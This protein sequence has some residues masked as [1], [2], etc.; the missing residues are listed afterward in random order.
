MKNQ[1]AIMIVVGIVCIS[2]SG[3]HSCQTIRSAQTD[4]PSDTIQPMAEEDTAE[5]DTGWERIHGVMTCVAESGCE[6]AGLH[7]PSWYVLG[8]E[9]KPPK[10]LD[11]YIL[12]FDGY[13]CN[14]ESCAC[15]ESAVRK[16]AYCNDEQFASGDSIN[17]VWNS[18]FFSEN[19]GH[20]LCGKGGVCAEGRCLCDGK[21][22]GPA[23]KNE[24]ECLEQR[25]KS[26]KKTWLCSN[27][28][29]CTCGDVICP[30]GATCHNGRCLCGTTDVT[31]TTPQQ[32]ADNS[33]LWCVDDKLTCTQEDGCSCGGEVCPQGAICH[34]GRCL[35]GTMD[36][37]PTTPQQRA[38]NPTLWCFNDKLIC[39]QEDGCSCGGEF[40]PKGTI[41][42][43][44]QCLCGKL[45]ISA[46]GPDVPSDLS[47]YTC[48]NDALLICESESCQCGDQIIE[49]E[50][51]EDCE[52]VV[53]YCVNG[54]ILEFHYDLESDYELNEKT[55]ISGAIRLEI[56]HFASC[57]DDFSVEKKDIC[58]DPNGCMT[59]DGHHMPFLYFLEYCHE[60]G[61]NEPL[62][63]NPKPIPGDGYDCDIDGLWICNDSTCEC[64]ENTCPEGSQCDNGKCS[65]YG[66]PIMAGYDCEEYEDG[67]QRCQQDSCKCGAETIKRDERCYKNMPVCSKQILTGCMCKGDLLK[68]RLLP[69]PDG[70]TCGKQGDFVCQQED[71][72]ICGNTK[73]SKNEKCQEGQCSVPSWMCDGTPDNLSDAVNHPTCI[74]NM[75]CI[76]YVD[77]AEFCM[78]PDGQSTIYRYRDKNGERKQTCPAQDYISTY[79]PYKDRIKYSG[80]GYWLNNNAY[81]PTCG[82]DFVPEHLDSYVCSIHDFEDC[83]CNHSSCTQ[84]PD[85]D[86]WLCID[87][88]GCKCGSLSC[89]VGSYCNK[90]NGNF[91]CGYQNPVFEKIC[92]TKSDQ[93]VCHSFSADLTPEEISRGGLLPAANRIPYHYGPAGWICPDDAGCACGNAICPK[94]HY[95]LGAGQCSLNTGTIPNIT[96][97]SWILGEVDTY[98]YYR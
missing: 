24:Y 7:Y 70:Y 68:G 3:C 32:R 9:P 56:E 61:N 31:P 1:I 76:Q 22:D 95:C 37:T 55:E 89:P 17:R 26:L 27:D 8:T 93:V 28:A 80:E 29:G 75:W 30:K 19:C 57:E 60:R 90:E 16:G 45:N 82:T 39:N 20:E 10:Q 74:D 98:E 77:A 18:D 34:N 86:G 6:H 69:L 40:C 25:D 35:C 73:C 11:G 85:F 67:I 97:K 47:G 21:P 64:G 36:V 4:A 87:P 33:T 41:C 94:G 78:C 65:C 23:N 83:S 53:Q 59:R 79:S 88:S 63:Y 52:H 5:E 72:C 50:E 49:N 42:H 84:Y 62:R 71:G 13:R 14:A 66:E 43:D 48:E 91:V 51:C 96:F 58:I 81:R 38:D 46:H 15:G 54:E 2:V 44:G 92:E 12:D